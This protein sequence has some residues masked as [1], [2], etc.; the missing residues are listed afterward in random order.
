MSSPR[1][2]TPTMAERAYL[3]EQRR[4]STHVCKPVKVVCDT[5]G[6]VFGVWGC[7]GASALRFVF[8]HDVKRLLKAKGVERAITH[9]CEA[10]VFHAARVGDEVR[11]E[12]A[13]MEAARLEEARIQA[14]DADLDAVDTDKRFS[15][16]EF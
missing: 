15:D 1:K 14:L 13:R 5:C 11:A 16:A 12:E 4:Q 2:T 7:K 8:G 9:V 6:C 3:A 10:C